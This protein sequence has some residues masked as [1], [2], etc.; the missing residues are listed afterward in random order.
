[1]SSYSI[2]KIVRIFSKTNGRCWYCGYKFN[3]DQQIDHV[4]PRSRGGSDEVENMVP[5]CKSCNSKKNT[6]T[7]EEYRKY[8][9]KDMGM[10]LNDNQKRW[11]MSKGIEIPE[12]DPVYFYME[13]EH[14]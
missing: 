4:I 9:Q 14:E 8:L 1:M 11:L 12:P 13:T 5:S 3:D 6:K 10:I 2:D 7:F